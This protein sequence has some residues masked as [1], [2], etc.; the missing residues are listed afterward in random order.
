MRLQIKS[1]IAVA[2]LVAVIATGC[3]GNKKNSADVAG[4]TTLETVTDADIRGQWYI[5]NIVFNDSDYVRPDETIHSVRQY[6][7]F[8]DSTY[9]IQTNC[10]TISGTY[11][12]KGDSITLGDG[13]MTEMACDDMSVEDALRRI[14]PDISTID[15]QNDSVVRLNG[16]TPAEC[17]LLRK[18]FER[19]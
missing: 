13:A 7:S 3:S 1:L 6:I 14:L 19:K 2:S 17:I 16:S 15:V 8:E 12:I 18:A 5:E 10:N 11:T 9:F 4:S